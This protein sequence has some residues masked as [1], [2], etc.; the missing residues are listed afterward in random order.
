MST[1]KHRSSRR[2]QRS[3]VKQLT[4]QIGG[5]EGA[6]LT[7]RD[8]LAWAL[9]SLIEAGEAGVAPLERP[10]PRWS[11]YVSN[12]RQKGL[13]IETVLE[14]HG[15]P[16]ASRRGRYILRSPIEIIDREDAA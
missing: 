11:R 9:L 6:I 8:R 14:R 5:T 12:L 4:V 13:G 3:Y 2:H 16:Y 1:L 7:F 10:A 15:G